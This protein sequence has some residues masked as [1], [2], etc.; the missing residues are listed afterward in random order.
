CFSLSIS[1]THR[2]P[3]SFPTRR[4]SDLEGPTHLVVRSTAPRS[5]R[6]ACGAAAG[7]WAQVPT[8]FDSIGTVIERCCVVRGDPYCEFRIAWDPVEGADTEGY[9]ASRRRS[10]ALVLRFEELLQLA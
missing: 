1:R 9:D 2:P 7:H 3:H 8:L 5:T 10:H 4:S 6:F